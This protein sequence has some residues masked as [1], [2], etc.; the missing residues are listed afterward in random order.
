MQ[1]DLAVLSPGLAILH[2]RLV[3]PETELA[4]L[5]KTWRS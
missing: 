3:R 4:I 1:L 5:K 2:A